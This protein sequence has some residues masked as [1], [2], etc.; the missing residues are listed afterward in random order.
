MMTV[1]FGGGFADLSMLTTNH[2]LQQW[3]AIAL[4][5]S[6]ADAATQVDRPDSTLLWYPTFPRDLGEGRNLLPSTRKD[7]D[8]RP[9]V[10]TRL[11]FGGQDGSRLSSLD[12]ITVGVDN[13]EESCSRLLYFLFHYDDGTT[14]TYSRTNELCDAEYSRRSGSYRAEQSFIINGR[15][16]ERITDQNICYCVAVPRDSFVAALKVILLYH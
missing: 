14:E 13:K 12:R 15:L 5:A 9:L 10:H 11:L 6:H 8:W 2:Q 16:G 4:Q 3:K 1:F 7:L